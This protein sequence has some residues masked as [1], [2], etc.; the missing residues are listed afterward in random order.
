MPKT[1]GIETASLFKSCNLLTE[2]H[3]LC[4]ARER[5]SNTAC[6][7]MPSGCVCVYL[8][9]SERVRKRTDREAE[10]EREMVMNRQRNAVPCVFGQGDQ[11]GPE[12]R[13]VL[14]GLDRETVTGV[15]KARGVNSVACAD[16]TNAASWPCM[17]LEINPTHCMSLM[18]PPDDVSGRPRVRSTI[19]CHVIVACSSQTSWHSL[20]LMATSLF[21]RNILLLQH[22]LDV[23]LSF[24]IGLFRFWFRYILNSPLKI[25]LCMFLI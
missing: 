12:Y 10:V 17:P 1:Q 14:W 4:S 18:R 22:L 15:L 21:V 13:G 25:A 2:G 3:I 23:V 9:C 19:T 6:L 5:A 24:I 20:W 7:L 8:C 16:I 11:G